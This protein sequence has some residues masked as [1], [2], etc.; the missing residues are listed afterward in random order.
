MNPGSSSPCSLRRQPVSV[1]KTKWFMFF[2]KIIV[3]NLA[4]HKKPINVVDGQDTKFRIISTGHM[5]LAVSTGLHMFK[6]Y[7]SQ[8]RR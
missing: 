3:I 2:R 1:R 5:Y 6:D 4:N 7:T 8:G